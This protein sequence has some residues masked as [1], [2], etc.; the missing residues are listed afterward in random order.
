[1][2][3]KLIIIFKFIE[4]LFWFAQA[5]IVVNLLK[6]QELIR[7]SG[8]IVKIRRGN[9]ELITLRYESGLEHRGALLTAE[10]N[11]AQASFQLAQAKRAVELAQR[12]LTKEMGRREFI[13]MSVK[14]AFIVFVV[15]LFNG[16]GFGG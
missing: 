3:Y 12:Q 16:R 9:L 13:S 15:L 6:A 8:E 11:L 7:V 10:A 4:P 1:M 2:T 5:L 14:A